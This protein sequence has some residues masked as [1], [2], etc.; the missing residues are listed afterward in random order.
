M[1]GIIVKSINK[2]NCGIYGLSIS[3]FSAIIYIIS[4]LVSI[5]D[6]INLGYDSEN[7]RIVFTFYYVVITSTGL[8]F[9]LYS[10]KHYIKSRMKDYAMY[11]VLG[12][13]K[14]RTISFMVIEYLIVALSGIIW[15]LI[16]GIISVEAISGIFCSNGFNVKL[17]IGTIIDN[18]KNTFLASGGICLI[19]CLVGMLNF[20]RKDLTRIMSLSIKGEG[21][22]RWLCVLAFCG[23]ILISNSIKI[24]RE[25]SLTIILLSLAENFVGMYIIICFGTSLIIS[26]V[27]HFAQ[28]IY[29]KNLFFFRS[30]E[31]RYK[32]NHTIIFL[33][34]ILS[35]VVIFFAGGMIITTFIDTEMGNSALVIRISSYFMAVFTI[36]CN[37]GILSIKKLNDISNDRKW[38]EI[39]RCLGMNQSDRISFMVSEFRTLTIVPAVLSIAFS[40]LY[41]VSECKRV[42]LMDA[43][44]FIGFA[45]FHIT[46]LLVQII[47]YKAIRLFLIKIG[48]GE[49]NG[50]CKSRTYI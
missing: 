8:L 43:D 48:I 42:E 31:Y 47:C 22:Y 9:V 3:L 40:W 37:M 46:L 23:L 30:F 34:Y 1:I 4:S 13:S 15:G 21:R 16:I 18:I 25:P 29:F 6:I 20:L 27:R 24:L 50:Y 10:L 2:K 49:L 38:V 11:I 41:I 44:H 5:N 39:L 45:L 32:S 36:V 35:V 26:F 28:G 19:G 33:T 12:T 17:S 14:K 7:V